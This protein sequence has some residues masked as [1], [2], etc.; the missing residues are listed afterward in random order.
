M[1]SLLIQ[2]YSHRFERCDFEYLS[3]FCCE[4]LGKLPREEFRCLTRPLVQFQ[5]QVRIALGALNEVRHP[6]LYSSSFNSVLQQHTALTSTS[7]FL[8]S[9]S[10]QSPEYVTPFSHDSAVVPFRQ[11]NLFMH[12]N[13]FILKPLFF[14]FFFVFSTR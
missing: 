4:N 11:I 5:M 3:E 10:Q 9:N 13:S 8:T 12:I 2:K 14:S 1:Q 7:S 6:F